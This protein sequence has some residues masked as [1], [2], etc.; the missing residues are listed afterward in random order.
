MSTTTKIIRPSLRIPVTKQFVTDESHSAYLLLPFVLTN[1]QQHF[2]SCATRTALRAKA[3]PAFPPRPV[4]TLDENKTI[5]LT[6]I[7]KA[8]YTAKCNEIIKEVLRDKFNEF[9]AGP[10]MNRFAYRDRCT[11]WR[12]DVTRNPLVNL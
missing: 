4:V 5:Q 10:V 8:L 7:K 1:K 12:C 3:L 9:T 2:S 6:I 11:Y